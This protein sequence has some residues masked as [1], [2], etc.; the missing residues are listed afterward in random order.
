M[1]DEAAVTAFIVHGFCLLRG[2]KSEWF[3][4]ISFSATTHWSSYQA[5]ATFQAD[6]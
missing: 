3:Y 1:M 4:A 2:R 6:Q 5:V